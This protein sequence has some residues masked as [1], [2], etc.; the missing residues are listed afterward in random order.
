[1]IDLPNRA[2]R[3]GAI[4][5]QHQNNQN[6]SNGN[7]NRISGYYRGKRMHEAALRL[8]IL[9]LLTEISGILMMLLRMDSAA[10]K[11]CVLRKAERPLRK[12]DKDNAKAQRKKSI[13]AGHEQSPISGL[14]ACQLLPGPSAAQS[15]L[16]PEHNR[17][18]LTANDW[19]SLPSNARLPGTRR[20]ESPESRQPY[21]RPVA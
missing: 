12:K 21:R 11:L 4:G 14:R 17:K 2:I 20:A 6:I 10:D 13:F 15:H 3:H 8:R 18:R 5:V 9:A 16:V 19:V 7:R 1:M